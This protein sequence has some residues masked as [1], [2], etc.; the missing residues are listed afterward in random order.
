M[1]TYN[2][3]VASWIADESNEAYI[4]QMFWIAFS[5]DSTDFQDFLNDIPKTDYFLMFPD[6]INDIN[7]FQDH[8]IDNMLHFLANHYY[9]GFIA[10]L[11]MPTL[12]DFKFGDKGKPHHWKVSSV[13]VSTQYIY[14][15]TPE[16]LFET[17]QGVVAK[18]FIKCIQTENKDFKA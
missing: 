11:E 17:V 2:Y 15:E 8:H 3:K 1:N 18:H 14:A 7:H 6:D 13:T 4:S 9:M 16:K 10:K 12:F 5:L